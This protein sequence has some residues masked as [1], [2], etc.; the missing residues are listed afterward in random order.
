MHGARATHK[1]DVWVC[2]SRFGLEARW[3]IECKY[4][5]SPVPKEKVLALKAIV[6]DVGADRGILISAAGFQSGAVRAADHT[7]I[8][9]TDLEDLTE[10]AQDD[11]L[12][13]ILHGLEDKAASLRA[14]LHDLY[15]SE[16]IG[17]NHWKSK[18]RPGV[19]GKA[20]MTVAGMLSVFE[21]GFDR[22]RLKQPP[23]PIKF[24][25][26]GDRQIVAHTVQEFVT[27][28]QEVISEAETVLQEQR[29]RLTN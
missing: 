11:L 1:I 28:G 8:T 12:S 25:E 24:D 17:R 19:D 21:F 13:S 4:W 22:V 20:V 14:A 7:N 2:F 5:K 23:F 27:L 10:L 18:P 15:V 26:T 16:K 6:E 29:A 9:L 3:V